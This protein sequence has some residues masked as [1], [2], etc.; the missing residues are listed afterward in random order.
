MLVFADALAITISDEHFDEDRFIAIGMDA[1]SRVLVVYTWRGNEIRLI[2]ARTI[3]R[4]RK[5]YGEG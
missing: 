4:E 5:Q 1:F 2:S 3:S